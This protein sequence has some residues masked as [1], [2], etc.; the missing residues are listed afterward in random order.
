M[1]DEQKFDPFSPGVGSIFLA[2]IWQLGLKE[3]IDMWPDLIGF[4]SRKGFQ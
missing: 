1:T 3:S 2:Y 4:C